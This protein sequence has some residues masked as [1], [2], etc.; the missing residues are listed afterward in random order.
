MLNPG[1]STSFIF[2][3]VI[4]R[5]KLTKLIFHL[6]LKK[7]GFTPEKLILLK[8]FEDIRWKFTAN[9]KHLSINVGESIKDR[10]TVYII[11]DNGAGFDMVYSDR[12]FVPF[13]RLH[14]IDEFSGTGIGLPIVQRIIHKHRGKIWAEGEIGKGATFYFT[15]GN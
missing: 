4:T 1:R 14:L 9:T 13:Q 12:L 15:V 2:S 8:I 6:L 7:R 11:K 3:P 5:K 10:Q